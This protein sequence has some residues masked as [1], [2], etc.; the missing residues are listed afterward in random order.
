VVD[1]VSG[2]PISGASVAWRVGDGKSVTLASDAAGK[3]KI[4]VP[5]KAAGAIRVTAGKDGFA[6]MTMRWEPD[7][8]PSRFD[9]LLPEA[10]SI[11]GHVT[12]EKGK[13]VADAGI[14]LILPQRLAGPRVAVEEF[15]VKSSPDGRW[16]CEIVP[17]DA[18]Y[19]FV[20]VSHPDFESPTGEVPLEALRAGTAEMQLQAVAT[21]R[22]R[23]LDE[24]GRAVPNA[25]LMLGSERNIGPGGSTVE[26]RADAD[27]RFELRRLALQ[28]RLLGTYAPGFAPALQLVEIK[29]D[30]APAEVRLKRGAPLRVRVADQAGQP[31]AGVAV[32]ADQWP[33]SMQR[34]SETL[35]GWWLFPGWE[36][37][38]DADGRV[39]WSNA[40]P[41]TIH[42]SFTKDGYMSR[43]HHGLKA[44]PEEQVVT[45]GLPFRAS[46]TVIDTSTGDPVKEFVVTPRYVV[47][48]SVLDSARTNFG[49]WSEY[50]RMPSF[51]GQFSLYRTSP[52]LSGSLEMHD[53]QFRVEADGYEPAVSRLVRDAERGT[54]LDFRLTPRPLPDLPAPAPSGARRVTAAAAVQP[55]KVRPGDTLT[56]FVKARVAPGH[57]IYALEDSGCSN[58]PTSLEA[59]LRGILKPDGP[60]R[61]PEPRTQEDGSRT[62]AAEMLFKRRF[63]VEE[64]RSGARSHK[65][66]A[67]LR[68]QVCNEALCW[69][70][71]TIPLETEFEVVAS[72][73]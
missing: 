57:H 45:L 54:R 1:A 49:Q 37:E 31:L 6:P 36:W 28:K 44:A 39:T 20:E 43:G 4:S 65:L 32:R 7:K 67:T 64:N 38:T 2:R 72:P 69:P 11:G 42:W 61:G 35:P 51:N 56:L 55:Q 23:V 50:N 60:W 8:V 22:G 26:A 3:V 34:G 63:L 27:G 15:P 68:F 47:I 29:R 52:L 41:E 14:S 5:R 30:A 25:E 70:A 13:P 12:D 58:L 62:L 24:T 18:A 33:A 40:P 21:M 48:Y 10:Q 16:R 59:S 53:W 71:E 46:G 66:P 9:L 17:K 73:E 19:V